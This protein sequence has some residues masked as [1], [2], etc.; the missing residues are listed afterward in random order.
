M[1]SFP[2]S[3]LQPSTSNNILSLAVYD[4]VRSSCWR[5]VAQ[6]QEPLSPSHAH[7]LCVPPVPFE[8]H[9]AIF[10]QQHNKLIR[11]T[12]HLHVKKAQLYAEKWKTEG[13][14]ITE[15][16]REKHVNFPPCS[17]LRLLLPYISAGSKSGT[18]EQTTSRSEVNEGGLVEGEVMSVTPLNA[19][20]IMR[21]PRKISN[22][23]LRREVIECLESDVQVS[24]SIDR[25]R[26]YIGAEHEY[27]LQR[28]IHAL[29]FRRSLSSPIEFDTEQDLR[30][31]RYKKTPDVR[32][33]K[34]LIVQC[35]HGVERC[36]ASGGNGEHMIC[37][38]DS[39]AT[40]GDPF[41]HEK[42]NEAQ[43]KAY[44]SLFGPGLVI[45]WLGFVETLSSCLHPSS[46]TASLVNTHGVLLWTDFP[47]IW[48][49]STETEWAAVR[50][51]LPPPPVAPI[52]EGA[53]SS[54]HIFIPALVATTAD[55]NI[56][57]DIEEEG[58]GGDDG[59]ESLHNKHDG[60][61]G[62]EGEDSRESHHYFHSTASTATTNSSA[63]RRFDLGLFA[64]TPEPV[65]D[66][67]AEP[68]VSTSSSSSSTSHKSSNAF[69]FSMGDCL[70]ASNLVKAR[71]SIN[72]KRQREMSHVEL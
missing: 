57:E 18:S 59:G 65:L 47:S 14:T 67:E 13:K 62:R 63:S 37:W 53:S 70:R 3:S 34:P 50:E 35:P 8:A 61:G 26:S 29:S 7:A 48:R 21:D 32:F 25:I 42:S 54:S 33:R 19:A 69:M 56:K 6:A 45:Y 16:A 60:G 38:V 23:R 43:I 58:M 46:K 22:E 68:P 64:M 41:T 4:R 36:R 9:L 12:H 28:L 44:T 15:I 39:K 40:F 24:P 49:P 71:E 2:S 11:T 72:Q 51:T 1:T 55:A 27:R 66:E 30:R 31:L 52:I 17:M 20:D 10:L 5:L